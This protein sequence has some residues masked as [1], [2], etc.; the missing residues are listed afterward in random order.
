M[1]YTNVLK[2]HCHFCTVFP[3]RRQFGLPAQATL[4]ESQQMMKTD[5]NE[6]LSYCLPSNKQIEMINCAGPLRAAVMGEDGRRMQHAECNW[7]SCTHWLWACVFMCVS[8]CKTGRAAREREREKQ[9]EWATNTGRG[10]Q[11]EHTIW[12]CRLIPK[13]HTRAKTHNYCFSIF[14]ICGGSGK[15]TLTHATLYF[16][17]F[18]NLSLLPCLHYYLFFYSQGHP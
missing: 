1:I 2:R 16:W 10:P 9:W 13:G 11:M 18:I 6:W 15:L 7:R 17:E 5:S 4:T 8:P 3:I 14:W 12:D